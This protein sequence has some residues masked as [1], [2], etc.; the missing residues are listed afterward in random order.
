MIIGIPRGFLYYKHEALWKG[1]FDAL[2]VKYIISPETNREI[3]DR[4]SKYAIDEACLSSKVYLGHVHWLI[5]RCDKIFV[6]RISSYGL[7]GEVCTKFPALY[8][9]VRNTFVDQDLEWI[10]YNVDFPSVDGETTG[11]IKLGK[12]LGKSRTKSL[13][14]YLIAKQGQKTQQILEENNVREAMEKKGLKILVVGHAYNLHDLYLG[15][16]VFEMLKKLDTIPISAARVHDKEIHQASHK[17]SRNIPW[18]FNRELVGTIAHYQDQID[19]I[20]LLTAFPCGPDSLI[21]ELILRRVKKPPVLQLILDGQEGT[22]GMETRLESFIDIIRF[23][24][25]G[26]Y[27]KI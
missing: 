7:D 18:I 25:E 15:T 14:A 6:P 22:A 16:P 8:D 13:R 4:G 5:G 26:Y 19:G 17:I 2:G 23:Q 9:L 1:F 3:L 12:Q 21:N 11:F 27:D 24:K 20:V 10:H